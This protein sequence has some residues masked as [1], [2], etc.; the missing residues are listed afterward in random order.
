MNT[1]HPQAEILR[2]LADGKMIQRF[3]P[4]KDRWKKSKF[5]LND[6]VHGYKLRIKPETITINGHEVP[7]PEREPLEKGQEYCSPDFKYPGECLYDQLDWTGDGLDVARLKAGVIHLT[8]EAA[9]SHAEALLSF[10][11]SDK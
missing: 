3:H 6:I 1:P 9:I 10:T 4:T 7:A 5:P 8:K 11:R 2:A